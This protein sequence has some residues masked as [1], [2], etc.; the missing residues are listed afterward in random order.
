[1]VKVDKHTALFSA[2]TAVPI[3]PEQR[4]DSVVWLEV[5]NPNENVSVEKVPVNRKGIFFVLGFTRSLNAS[6]LPGLV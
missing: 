2:Q 5:H 6:R 3:A 1:M 4:L